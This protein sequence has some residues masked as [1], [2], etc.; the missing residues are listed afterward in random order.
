MDSASRFVIFDPAALRI[1]FLAALK[2]VRHYCDCGQAAVRR[3]VTHGQPENFGR[4]ILFCG[5]KKC[6]F[7]HMLPQ[8]YCGR[9][10]GVGTKMNG[11]KYFRCG[12]KRDFCDFKDCF[13][14][15]VLGFEALKGLGAGVSRNQ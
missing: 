11:E 10:A 12:S 15:K 4:E 1:D 2:R 6:R 8:C 14:L 3:T 7:I 5:E 9:A 13:G